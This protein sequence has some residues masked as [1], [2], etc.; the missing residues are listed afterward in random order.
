[1]L[2]NINIMITGMYFFR[3]AHWQKFWAQGQDMAE[4][5]TPLPL[6]VFYTKFELRV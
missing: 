6:S 5:S 4:D 2:I 1:M 3:Q